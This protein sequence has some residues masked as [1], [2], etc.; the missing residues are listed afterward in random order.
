MTELEKLQLKTTRDENMVDI[1]Q[2][3]LE[4]AES[5]VLSVTNRDTLLEQMKPLVR[6]VAESYYNNYVDGAGG[7]IASKSQG[8]VSVSYS[9]E[10][11]A[12]VQSRVLTFRRLKICG[13][14]GN[15]N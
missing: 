7:N 1:L 11:P 8:D 14:I 4:D 5:Y 13:V 15:E 12:K 3:M 9:Q 6:E 10:V 2:L